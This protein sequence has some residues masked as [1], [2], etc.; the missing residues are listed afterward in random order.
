LILTLAYFLL[1]SIFTYRVPSDPDVRLVKGLECTSFAATVYPTA[2]P[3]LGIDALKDANYE[4]ELLW[5]A[6]TISIVHLGLIAIWIF[7]YLALSLLVAG[8]LVTAGGD[9][10][11]EG[12]D[13]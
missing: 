6:R 3:F 7:A 13:P 10:A 9:T 1:A 11:S 5:T 8:F 4:A 12:T 2:C